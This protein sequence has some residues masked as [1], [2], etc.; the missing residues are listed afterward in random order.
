MKEIRAAIP[1]E[2]FV[3]DTIRGLSYFARDVLLAAT[4]W[5]CATFI[6]PYFQS[7][8]AK[9]LLTPIGAEVARWA[10]WGV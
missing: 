10:A 6:D 4:A 5:T 3:R 2:Y 9:Q 7:A 8:A 1:P